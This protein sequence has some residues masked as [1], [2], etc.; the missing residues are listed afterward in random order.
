MDASVQEELDVSENGYKT[1]WC[2]EQLM[3]LEYNRQSLLTQAMLDFG[4][5][6]DLQNIDTNANCDFEDVL[7]LQSVLQDLKE[8][9]INSKIS[10][11]KLLVRHRNA[12]KALKAESEKRALDPKLVTYNSNL[13]DGLNKKLQ[14]A[15]LVNKASMGIVCDLD[16]CKKQILEEICLK[17]EHLN[18]IL[19]KK[20][21]YERLALKFGKLK[22]Q[23]KQRQSELKHLH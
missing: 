5:A 13:L 15:C 11:Y 6:P 9:L 8:D 2:N 18:K 20:V 12:L 7:P 1:F 3:R 23:L 17:R 16:T 19:S 22:M 21:E 14:T 10:F 4:F